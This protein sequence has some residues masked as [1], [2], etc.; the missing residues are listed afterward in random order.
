MKKLYFSSNVLNISFSNETNYILL[1]P[2]KYLFEAYGASGGGDGANADTT[3]RIPN[4][5]ECL[6]QI[7]VTKFGGNTKCNKVGS[8]PGAGG[9]SRGIFTARSTTPIYVLTGGKGNYGEGERP[10]GFNGGGSAC[11]TRSSSGSG[12]GATDFRLFYNSLYSRI[13][14]AG[15]G[16]GSDDFTID[17]A[18]APYMG[19][20]DGSGGS[21]GLIGQAMWEDGNYKG[22]QYE[23]NTTRG[24]SF[25]QGER[26][27]SCTY[28]EKA[29]AGGG[30]FGGFTI[31]S[32]S[33]G[34]GGGSSFAFSE[35]IPFPTTPIEAKDENGVILEKT[36]YMFKDKP[37]YYLTSVDFA[38]GIWSGDGF[39]RI[40]IIHL[41]PL[42]CCTKL[43]DFFISPIMISVLII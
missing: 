36:Y 25:G 18:N 1:K 43:N 9:Y 19:A 3:S 14:V 7:N 40:T 37:E 38:T 15:G 24:F 6:D 2:G 16:G 39:A 11:S 20:N 29:G 27:K 10:G 35:G 22:S 17:F 26:S 8:Q 42:N 34:A 21:G 5:K 13:L 30:F 28:E 23:T 32:D 4:E 31:D 12:G 33:A 41:F